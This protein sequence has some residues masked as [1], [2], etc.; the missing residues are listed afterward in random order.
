[1]GVECFLYLFDSHHICEAANGYTVRF[2]DEEMEPLAGE[3][4]YQVIQL[5][6]NTVS[7]MQTQFFLK[8]KKIQ[9]FL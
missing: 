9:C 8:K 1:M 6:T 7:L 3:D 4:L 2:T 5:A